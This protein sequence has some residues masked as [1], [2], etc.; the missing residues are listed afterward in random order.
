MAT[1][2][3]YES[4]CESQNYAIAS[5]HWATMVFEIQAFEKPSAA[6]LN[7]EGARDPNVKESIWVVDLG[8]THHT[9][10]NKAGFANMKKLDQDVYLGVN[11]FINV[12]GI[13][14]VEL[15]IVG[16]R[17]ETMKIE[18]RDCFYIPYMARNLLSVRQ[19]R[20]E[21]MWTSTSSQIVWC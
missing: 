13:G 7:A 3:H 6:A 14:D 19:L 16:D 21:R 8:R 1:R 11:T 2:E 12:K 10:Y 18:L 20:T 4:Q 17:G 9:A 5:V 15:E